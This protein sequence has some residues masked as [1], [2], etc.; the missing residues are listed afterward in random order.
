MSEADELTTTDLYRQLVEKA[1][2]QE[3]RGEKTRIYRE[4]IEKLSEDTGDTIILFQAVYSL[5][6]KTYPQMKVVR[7][8]LRNVAE[9]N[10]EVTIDEKNP[11]LVWINLS[12]PKTPRLTDG[13]SV[14]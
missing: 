11:N 3:A 10:W 7:S 8:H 13:T 2:L 14:H 4:F 1:R 6:V 9:H 12:K 5:L